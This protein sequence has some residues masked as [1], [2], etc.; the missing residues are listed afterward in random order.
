MSEPITQ[1]NCYREWRFDLNGPSHVSAF[2]MKAPDD[3]RVRLYAVDNPY[4]ALDFKSR[5]HVDDFI[6][7]LQ[8]LSNQ[9]WPL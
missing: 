2:W 5:V 6:L 3:Q 7:Q 1:D 9:V 8:R 4:Y